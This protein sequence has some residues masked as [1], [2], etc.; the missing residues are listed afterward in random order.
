MKI[1]TLLASPNDY[2]DK[3][4]T[5]AGTIIG[6]CQKRGCWMSLA[7]DA[8]FEKLRLKVRDGDMV[9]PMT[10]KGRKALAT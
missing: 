2:L 8:K 5:V 4:I 6:V 7:S 1:S 9:F 10:A 3:K